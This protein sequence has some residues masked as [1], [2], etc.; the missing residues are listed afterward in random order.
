MFF[1]V[2]ADGLGDLFLGDFPAA[3]VLVHFE[4]HL[5]KQALRLEKQERLAHGLQFLIGGVLDAL[6]QQRAEFLGVGGGECAHGASLPRDARFDKVRRVPVRG[7]ERKRPPRR[8]L[9]AGDAP[10]RAREVVRHRADQVCEPL[11]SRRFM[12]PS[13]LFGFLLPLLALAG[14]LH[15]ATVSAD[16]GNTVVDTTS[17]FGSLSVSM[18]R[19]TA[20]VLENTGANVGIDDELRVKATNRALL[21]SQ[22]A[23]PEWTALQ[24]SGLVADGV[25]PLLFRIARTDVPSAAGDTYELVLQAGDA[26]SGSYVGSPQALLQVAGAYVCA[27]RTFITLSASQPEAFVV[28]LPVRPEDLQPNALGEVRLRLAVKDAVSGFTKKSFNFAL[29]RPPLVLVHGYNADENG[30]S[31]GFRDTVDGG[32]A[33]EFLIRVGYGTANG[34]EGNTYNALL[35]LAATL[36][37]ELRTQVEKSA[38]LGRWAWT[39]YDAVG[40]SQGGVLLRML[41]SQ[42]QLAGGANLSTLGFPAF[43]SGDNMNRGR[44]RRVVTIGSPHAGSTLA[45]MGIQLRSRG[46]KF[47]SMAANFADKHLGD[48]DYLFQSKFRIGSGTPLDEINTTLQCDPL[49]RLHMVR[50]TIYDGDAPGENG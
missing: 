13:R 35:P 21:G 6:A 42:G 8:K 20:A 3:P 2:F 46:V 9:R 7:K 31:A 30:W 19:P 5:V 4:S 10:Q 50:T 23:L 15:A 11:D 48:L 43:R 40:H 32:R 47:G 27:A 41:C 12:K 38:V 45:E 17:W 29:R 24:S 39:R 1:A 18:H 26:A 14:T 37:E 49:A 33:S 28:I 36:S 44:F 16:S 25:T 22:P 34:N